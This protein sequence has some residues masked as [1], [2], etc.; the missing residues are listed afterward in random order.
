[1]AA[2]TDSVFTAEVLKE[3]MRDDGWILELKL[4]MGSAE[5]VYSIRN[6]NNTKLYDWKN[7][8]VGATDYM[9]FKSTDNTCGSLTNTGEYMVIGLY[10]GEDGDEPTIQST[11]SV[12]TDV[13][14][15][16]I[17]RAINYADVE[18]LF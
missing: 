3:R 12:S 8:L 16:E 7:F 4:T 5:C 11:M 13:A 10:K 1:M 6:A 14:G 2:N 9:E 15:P 18:G 17:L